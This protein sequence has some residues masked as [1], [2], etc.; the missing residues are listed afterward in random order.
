MR[1]SRASPSARS[2][3]SSWRAAPARRAPFKERPGARW[4]PGSA[5]T[6]AAPQGS[7]CSTTRRTTATSTGTTT[8]KRTAPPRRTSPA[9]TRPRR[10]RTPRPPGS[11][12]TACARST[13]SMG[14]KAVYDLSATP[15]FL[16]GS[17]Y[18]EGTLFPWVVSDFGL[19][20]AIESGIVKIPRVPVDDNATTPNVRS[21][22]TSGRASRTACRRRAASAGAVTPDQ[23]A[24]P[25]R[26]RAHRALRLLRPL[27][28]RLG[29]LRREEV[30]RARPRLHRR[31]QQ[32]HRL[33]DGLRLH[34]RL[35]EAPQRL[36]VRLGARQALAVQQRRARQAD[37]PAAH[38]PRRLPPVRVRRGPVRGVQEDRRHRDRGVP[39]RVR[40]P[41]PRPQGRG[42]GRR[43]RSCAR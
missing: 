25:A 26:R 11:G 9:T 3:R 23:T 30:R 16:S 18:Q 28:R 42:H 1:P 4:S 17:G 12:S 24:R 21:S 31:L 27:V 5:A 19:V 35:G 43:D 7:W 33:Q 32:H 37:R 15:S 6:S 38:D 39:R 41:R 20:E 40:P 29:G 22:S 10:P 36:P 34:R 14:V 8:R 2:P 13:R